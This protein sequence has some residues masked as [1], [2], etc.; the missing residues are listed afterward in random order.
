MGGFGHGVGAVA[1]PEE[2][3]RCYLLLVKGSR[4]TEPLGCSGDS[5]P[6]RKMRCAGVDLG[7]AGVGFHLRTVVSN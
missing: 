1:H 7:E 4:Q 6:A 2:T 3:V 5:D